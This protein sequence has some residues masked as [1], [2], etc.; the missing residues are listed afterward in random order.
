LLSQGI[1]LKRD[2][3]AVVGCPPD[4]AWADLNHMLDPM[5]RLS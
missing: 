1:A 3:P 5:E 4:I 2:A